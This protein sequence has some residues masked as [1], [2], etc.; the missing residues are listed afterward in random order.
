M[1]GSAEDELQEQLP[2][3]PSPAHDPST[4]LGDLHLGQANVQPILQIVLSQLL[5]FHAEIV[6]DDLLN[7][8][9]GAIEITKAL[10]SVTENFRANSRKIK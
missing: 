10:I 4:G 6:P 5:L 1:T 8:S 7:P 2:P 3:L 9:D